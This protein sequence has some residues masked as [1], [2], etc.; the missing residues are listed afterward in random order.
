M[1][2]EPCIS[3]LCLGQVVGHYWRANLGN[4]SRVP[5]DATPSSGSVV[6]LIADSAIAARLAG[7]KPDGSN[8]AVP[9]DATSGAPKDGW[10]FATG[11][12]NTRAA[13]KD[14]PA[15]QDRPSALEEVER[16]GTCAFNR[17]RQPWCRPEN[18]A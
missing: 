17:C 18:S 5:K 8:D 15:E 11:S 7:P 3:A 10:A 9:T 1:V 16:H 2:R 12:E 13:C 6:T 14:V 4:F